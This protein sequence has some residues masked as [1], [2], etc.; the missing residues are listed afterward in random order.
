MKTKLLFATAIVS[1]NMFAQVPEVA[2]TRVFNC[3]G[4]ERANSI[5]QTTDGGYIIAGFTDANGG[6][7]TGNH[8]AKDYWIVKLDAL[9]NLVW[10]KSLGGS[11]DDVPYSIQQTN[12]DGY[13]V[14]G[15]T[16]SN[17]GDVTDHHGMKDIWIVKMDVT[18]SIVWQKTFGGSYNDASFSIQQ[19]NDGGYI[20]GGYCGSTDTD[21]LVPSGF[22][23]FKLDASANVVWKKSLPGIIGQFA[24][25]LRQTADG[26]YIAGGAY[27]TTTSLYPR[28]ES[29]VYKLDA[30]GNEVWRNSDLLGHHFINAVLQSSDGNFI[31]VGFNQSLSSNPPIN[32]YQ[33]CKSNLVKL[34]TNG[35]NIWLTEIG[36]YGS[37]EFPAANMVTSV[38]ETVDGGYVVGDTYFI[39]TSEAWIEKYNASG[40]LVW[41]MI[42][43]PGS[44]GDIQQTS[45]GGFVFCN[46][47]F[48]ITKLTHEILSS[49]GFESIEPSVIYPNPTQNEISLNTKEV[50]QS[51]SITDITGKLLFQ[52]NEQKDK[53]SLSD[54]E[55]GVYL[56]NIQFTSGK[57]ETHKIIKD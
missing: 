42:L 7:V 53:I 21:V 43:Q 28:Y 17:D 19:T 32:H 31:A 57:N 1:W 30:T 39:G 40:D 24:K 16:E 10:Q 3:P 13:I 50:Y 36:N 6:D 46:G 22:L 56:I 4:N 47:S 51:V 20:V 52:T 55:S 12:D 34:D 8:G 26:G 35:H 41:R 23:I 11:A 29:R 27:D 15:Y 38:C 37:G 5:D 9:G 18:G 49:S 48:G 45:D 2:W 33:G 54:Y 44:S 25:V 14:T